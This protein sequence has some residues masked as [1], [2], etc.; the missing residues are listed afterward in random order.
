MAAAA[1]GGLAT[2]GSSTA[3]TD[4]ATA[5]SNLPAVENADFTFR[6]LLLCPSAGLAGRSF[7]GER[8]AGG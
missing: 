7:G 6:S 5:V 8:R 3:A 1:G 4:T 2:A